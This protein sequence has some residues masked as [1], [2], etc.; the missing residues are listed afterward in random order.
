[1]KE[2]EGVKRVPH[3]KCH[4]FICRSIDHIYSMCNRR[5][6]VILL[7]AALIP[8]RER[9][10]SASTLLHVT[11]TAQ[12]SLTHP[13]STVMWNCFEFARR[14]TVP[15]TSGTNNPLAHMPRVN[16]T[17]LQRST[18][19]GSS[20]FGYEPHSSFTQHSIFL[21]HQVPPLRPNIR[22]SPPRL[23]V[24]CWQGRYIGFHSLNF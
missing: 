15:S 3:I 24:P 5:T 8:E 23:I 21:H 1:M 7:L 20:L 2:P 11:S 6:H 4:R 17:P 9:R 12:V 14:H 10:L 16:K 13:P 18:A 19:A 22:C